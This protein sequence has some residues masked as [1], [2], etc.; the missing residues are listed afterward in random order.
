MQL[1]FYILTKERYMKTILLVAA[2]SFLSLPVLAG[3]ENVDCP[4]NNNQQSLV[5]KKNSEQKIA[6]LLGSRASKS[7]AKRTYS[8]R[9]GSY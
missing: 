7:T 9:R 2:V 6:H 1:V 5:S 8:S 3:Q 4:H